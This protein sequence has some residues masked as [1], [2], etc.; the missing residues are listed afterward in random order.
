MI[1]T[2]QLT[3]TFNF[4]LICN[5]ARPVIRNSD[6]DYTDFF[7][8]RLPIRTIEG[9]QFVLDQSGAVIRSVT[10]YIENNETLSFVWVRAENGVMLQIPARLHIVSASPF[11][12]RLYDMNGNR[13]CDRPYFV[14]PE[15][16]RLTEDDAR[17]R[18][19]ELFVGHNWW[20]NLP[21]WLRIPLNG[22]RNLFRLPDNAFGWILSIGIGII[23]GI[24][25]KVIAVGLIILF[26][27]AIA[28]LAP[29]IAPLL[30]SI[31]SGLGML[32]KMP[33]KIHPLFGVAVIAFI[34]VIVLVIIGALM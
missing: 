25:L 30:P 16:D 34:A 14:P 2:G 29:I 13:L 27:V 9:R 17:E 11:E 15:N 1:P 21:L 18:Y 3:D 7:G 8:N 19:P 31:M 23:A 32:A 4:V 28:F 22:I 12:Y 33:F 26:A 20:D 5:L 24:I 6:G 10:R